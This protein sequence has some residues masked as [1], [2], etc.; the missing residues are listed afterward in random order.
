MTIV[1]VVSKGV[2]IRNDENDT[3]APNLNKSKKAR[4]KSSHQISQVLSVN[5]E[6]NPRLET[7][8]KMHFYQAISVLEFRQAF[9]NC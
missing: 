4:K 5:Q 7:R 6:N 3:L 8:S 9:G 2:M 1:G